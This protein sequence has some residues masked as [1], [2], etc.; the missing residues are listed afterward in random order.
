MASLDDLTEDLT[1]EETAGVQSVKTLFDISKKD[2]KSDIDLK[3]E[4]T[5]NE[6][7]NSAMV[8]FIEGLPNKDLGKAEFVINGLTDKFKRLKVSKERKGRTEA[9][10]IFR[11]EMTGDVSKSSWLGNLFKPKE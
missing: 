5:D 10:E 4:L 11:S 6:I 7:I 1:K 2:G 8:E 3:T 9:V